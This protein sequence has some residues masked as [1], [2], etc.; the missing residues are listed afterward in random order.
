[1]GFNIAITDSLRDYVERLHYES[2]RYQDLLGTVRRDF[3][4][5]TD[6]E[7]QSSL[8]YYRNLCVDASESLKCA[9]DTLYELYGDQI[10]DKR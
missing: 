4:P 10:G 3:S 9:M 2:V 8:D 7:W 5:M 6:D 1:M